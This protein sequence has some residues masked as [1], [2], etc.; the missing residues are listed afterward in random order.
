GLNVIYRDPPRTK[1]ARQAL[2]EGGHRSLGERIDR[3]SRKRNAVAVTTPDMNDSAALAH[4][5]GGLLCRDKKSTDVNGDHSIKVF[6]RKFLDRS[7][8][9]NSGIVDEDIN[10][11]K[12]LD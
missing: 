8:R 10:T 1:I 7:D 12:R 6:Y 11:A 5:A 4:V 3:R 9:E 2:S